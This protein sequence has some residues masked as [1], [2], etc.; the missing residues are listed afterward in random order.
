[1]NRLLEGNMAAN[2]KDILLKWANL[3]TIEKKDNYLRLDT[4][5]ECIKKI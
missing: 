1:M 3:L 4:A 2:D 5:L